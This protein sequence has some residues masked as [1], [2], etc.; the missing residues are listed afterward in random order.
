MALLG[1]LPATLSSVGLAMQTADRGLLSLHHPC[2]SVPHN[3]CLS[4]RLYILLVLFLS[5]TLTDTSFG[6]ERHSRGHFKDG[7]FPFELG[8]L[9]GVCVCVC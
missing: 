3:K 6:S 7:F 1:G 9:Y 2:E 5:G 8:V 4:R